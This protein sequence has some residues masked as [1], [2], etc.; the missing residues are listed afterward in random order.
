M[1]PKML[2]KKD[3]CEYRRRYRSFYSFF[4]SRTTRG[5]DWIG[6]APTFW[7]RRFSGTT[8]ESTCIG[9]N[10]QQPIRI[11]ADV[12]APILFGAKTFERRVFQHRTLWSRFT[13]FLLCACQR[14][15][16]SQS[17]DPLSY[18]K[19][20]SVTRNILTKCTFSSF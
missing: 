20:Y 15:Y 5:G 12:L 17:E 13:F 16:N 9:A 7:L 6:L 8:L 11:G 10:V 4:V 19:I 3:P 18:S 1:Y 2:G 14:F